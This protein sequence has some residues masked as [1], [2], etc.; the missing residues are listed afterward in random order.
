MNF[1]IKEKLILQISG[2]KRRSFSTPEVGRTK[3][4]AHC[5]RNGKFIFHSKKKKKKKKNDRIFSLA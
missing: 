3:K 5:L 1:Q 2:G 4:L